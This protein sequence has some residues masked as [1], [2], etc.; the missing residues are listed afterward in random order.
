M[1]ALL[2]NGKGSALLMTTVF[3]LVAGGMLFFLFTDAEFAHRFQKQLHDKTLYTQFIS[4]IKTQL[5][6]PDQCYAAL[7]KQIYKPSKKNKVILKTLPYN[8]SS[9]I[10]KNLNIGSGLIIAD[11]IL[12]A[13]PFRLFS[14]G[15]RALNGSKR[16]WARDRPF[17]LTTKVAQ[18]LIT[19]KSHL[20]Y[21]FKAIPIDLFINIDAVN[22]IYSC[23]TELSVAY[24]CENLEN[25]WNAWR[26][27]CEPYKRCFYNKPNLCYSP[28][29]RY[30][31]GSPSFPMFICEWC[32]PN[33]IE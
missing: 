13:K 31:V 11:I 22:K 25:V 27:Q 16:R 12:Q 28:Y 18:L 1:Y 26:G 15:E 19:V 29:S 5:S 8:N 9:T 2:L 14:K 17:R 20:G 3:G 21:N 32:N 23:Y 30:S 33:Q 6:W 10:F 24:V 7:N 4:N